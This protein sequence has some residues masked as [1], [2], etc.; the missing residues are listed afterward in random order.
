MLDWDPPARRYG[1]V[2]VGTPHQIRGRTFKVVFVPG[3][4]E[5]IFP[6]RVR[7]DPLLPDD[8][9]RSAAAGLMT[10]NGRT[11]AERLLLRLAL[12]AATERVYLSYPR[13]GAEMGDMRPR[14]PS[15]YALD[16]MRAMTGRVPDHRTLAVEAVEQSNMSLAW[17]A[18][19]DP[20]RAVDDLEHDLATLAPLLEARDVATVTG[21][22]RYLL[23]LNPALRRSVG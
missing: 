1:R 17:P 8:A 11:S 3:L 10:R 9:R 6:Q 19:R 15:F 21:H 4:A 5:R 20:A 18:P 23:E 2:F 16:V 12:G 22:A 7:E 13:L 14:V